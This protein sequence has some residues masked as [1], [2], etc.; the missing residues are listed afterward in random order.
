[1][2]DK[3]FQIFGQ[4][5]DQKHRTALQG[6]RVEAWDSDMFRDDFVGADVTDA[7]GNFRI[8]FTQIYFREL[9]FDRAPDLYFK[10]FQ[11]RELIASTEDSVLWNIQAG[12]Q[13][14]LIEVDYEDS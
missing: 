3:T 2:R 14:V 8:E 11:D 10:I 4:V 9:F 1:M 13:D 5:I 6:L 7:D 12:D